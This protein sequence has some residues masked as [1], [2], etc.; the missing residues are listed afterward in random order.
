M[1]ARSRSAARPNYTASGNKIRAALRAAVQTAAWI[2]TSRS[3]GAASGSGSVNYNRGPGCF[4]ALKGHDLESGFENSIQGMKEWFQSF[5]AF[6]LEKRYGLPF[7]S[8]YDPA[9]SA[10]RRRPTP[11]SNATVSATKSTRSIRCAAA[12]NFSAE[13]RRE[14]RLLQHRSS[15][16]SAAALADNAG[17][18]G[19]DASELIGGSAGLPWSAASLVQ[20]GDC[21]GKF[22]VW[23]YQNMPG[24]A[25]GQTFRDGRKMKSVWPHLYY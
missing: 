16:S 18:G 20:Y 24:Q 7:A 22:L 2:A 11:I 19:A 13:R 25:S 9:S 23:W 14:L 3:A 12:C 15:A 6:D 4:L 10:T 21:G 5:A 17:S 8:T 1:P